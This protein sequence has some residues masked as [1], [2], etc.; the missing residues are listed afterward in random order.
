MTSWR[1]VEFEAHQESG[2]LLVVE[3]D[4][5]AGKTS[6][7]A[8][9][10][11]GTDVVVVPQLERASAGSECRDSESEY[12]EDWYVEAERA[13]QTVVRN[14]L[15]A[16][17]VVLQDRSVLSTAAFVYAS[18]IHRGSRRN[19]VDRFLRYLTQGPAFLKPDGLIIMQVA[20]DVGIA[21]RPTFRYS[22]RYRPWFDADFLRRFQEFYR[23]IVPR[24]LACPTTIVDTSA[25]S[26]QEVV[27]VL[28]RSYTLLGRA[29]QVGRQ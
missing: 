21:R 22:D 11:W 16:G 8:S 20:I 15:R 12:P 13:R 7:I 28:E 1:A 9:A 29:R 2:R 10:Q 14:A 6:S 24:V 18:A 3:G 19:R 4:P 25:L 27:G 26:R 23:R 5:G 17:R